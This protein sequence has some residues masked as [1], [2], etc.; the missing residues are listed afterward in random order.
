MK[1]CWIETSDPFGKKIE[2]GK[3]KSWKF[4]KIKQTKQEKKTQ[5]KIKRNFPFKKVNQE[6]HQSG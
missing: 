4:K 6:Q 2:L 3:T 5:Q 1:K